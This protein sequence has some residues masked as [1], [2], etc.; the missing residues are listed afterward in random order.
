M[1]HRVVLERAHDV[2][3]RIRG[4]QRLQELAGQTAIAT[5]TAL[6]TGDIDKLD[7]RRHEALRVLDGRQRRHAFIGHLGDTGVDGHLGR[8]V[9]LHHHA[10]AGQRVEDGGLAAVGQTDDPDLEARHA[11]DD[12]RGW[13][14]P[15]PTRGQEPSRNA[16]RD[17][18]ERIPDDDVTRM[19][20]PEVDPAAGHRERRD[21][22]R[23]TR[24][25]HGLRERE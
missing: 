8:R 19:M 16:A 23:Q 18:T 14:L 6:Q 7:G 13:V 21:L 10:R 9:G 3:Q 17:R 15:A 12:I 20:H 11:P 4:A 2:D 24:G 25:R 1:K 5:A 22:E